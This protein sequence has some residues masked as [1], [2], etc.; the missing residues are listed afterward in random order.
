[1][2]NKDTGNQIILAAGFYKEWY[3]AIGS[4]G[5]DGT[6]LGN[7]HKIF[8]KRFPINVE[9]I[10]AGKDKGLFKGSNTTHLII[11]GLDFYRAHVKGP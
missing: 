5:F 11:P 2:I 9:I 1:M 4:F 10:R 3:K 6:D 8:S 7:I